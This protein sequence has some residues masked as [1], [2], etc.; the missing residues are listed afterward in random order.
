[1]KKFLLGIMISAVSVPAF[2]EGSCET[3]ANFAQNVMIARQNGVPLTHALQSLEKAKI[4][5]T[6]LAKTKDEKQALIVTNTAFKYIT[7]EAYKTPLYS[8]DKYKQREVSEFS[9]KVYLD[10][11]NSGDN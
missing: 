4:K 3:L 11:L 10:C 9:N 8:T 7:V 6:K 1:M 2:A 5:F